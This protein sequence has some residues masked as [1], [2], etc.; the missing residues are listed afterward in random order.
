MSTLD[1]LKR[2]KL[3]NLDAV[4]AYINTHLEAYP[5]IMREGE[6]RSIH[7]PLT[8]GMVP[9]EGLRELVCDRFQKAGWHHMTI[10]LNYA[11]LWFPKDVWEAQ[12]PQ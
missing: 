6:W 8:E 4:V 9:D 5:G 7:I 3:D 11:T 12:C 2:N 10:G 1:F